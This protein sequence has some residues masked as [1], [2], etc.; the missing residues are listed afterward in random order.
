MTTGRM[1]NGPAAKKAKRGEI[2]IKSGAYAVPRLN[3]AASLLGFRRIFL[4]RIA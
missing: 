4:C 3:W 2:L 1:R